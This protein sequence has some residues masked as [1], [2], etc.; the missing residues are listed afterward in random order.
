VRTHPGSR[1]GPHVQLSVSDTGI[2]RDALTQA[3]IFEPF[4][5]TKALGEGS[6]LG[7]AT[8][9]GIVK[10]SGGWIYVDSEPGHGT[11]FR[12]YLPRVVEVATAVEHPPAEVAPPPAS[13]ETVLVV[14]DEPAVRAFAVRVL[15]GLGYRVLQAANGA[16]AL[17][18]AAGHAGPID[19]LLTDVIMPG[20]QGRE[21]GTRIT[22]VRP[23]IRVL[24]MSAFMDSQSGRADLPAEAVFLAK[25]FT[26]EALG[27]AVR[28]A[29]NQK[30]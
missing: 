1:P 18:L 7:L 13:S 3:H 2:G 26:V 10:Q 27:D 14:E 4:F 30:A 21:L 28:Q 16:E 24:Y 12:I 19:L 11:T 20:I 29:L 9:Y 23:V 15:A 17:E 22:A 6:G 25:P 5:T 8:V